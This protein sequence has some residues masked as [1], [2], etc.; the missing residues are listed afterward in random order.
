MSTTAYMYV[1][2][3]YYRNHPALQ[4]TEIPSNYTQEKCAYPRNFI[5]ALLFSSQS[6]N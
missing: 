1:C 4:L 3:V 6:N 2:M 5:V